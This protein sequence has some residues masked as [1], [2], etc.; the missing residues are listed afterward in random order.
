MTVENTYLSY[1]LVRRALERSNLHVNGYLHFHPSPRFHP[2]LENDKF[3]QAVR[4]L[5]KANDAFMERHKDGV[6]QLVQTLDTSDGQL[7]AEFV[8]AAGQVVDEIRWGRIASLFFLT[9]LLAERLMKE[10]HSNKI[11][12]LVMWLAQFLNDHVSAWIVQK[13]GWVSPCSV[14]CKTSS[15][16]TN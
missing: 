11:D 16:S 10:G 12:S 14:V 6:M 3:K 8:K 4:T 9:S 5:E 1:H 2:I 15:Y 7:H 13:G